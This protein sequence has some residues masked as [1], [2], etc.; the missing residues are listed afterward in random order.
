MRLLWNLKFSGSVWIRFRDKAGGAIGGGGLSCKW[1]AAYVLSRGGGQR[2]LRYVTTG[3]ADDRDRSARSLLVH[4]S[5]FFKFRP[6]Q[7]D[8]QC[9]G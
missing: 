2:H 7:G 3:V 1:L 6:S 8:G 4:R 9:I 5:G